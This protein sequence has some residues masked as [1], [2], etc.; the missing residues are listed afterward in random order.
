[1]SLPGHLLRGATAAA[2]LAVATSGCSDAAQMSASRS[3][4]P[5]A[6]SPSPTPDKVAIAKQEILA[7]YRGTFADMDVAVA[8]GN[9]ND[10]A[11]DRHAIA[12]ARTQLVAAVDFYLQQ[13][14]VPKGVPQAKIAFKSLDLYSDPPLATLQT[15]VDSSKVPL[16]DAKTGK[17]ARGFFSRPTLDTALMTVWHGRWV[18]EAFKNGT[19]RC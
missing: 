6:A 3:P 2:I 18:V 9:R 5:T 4:S 1:M 14:V 19:T 11:L 8:H 13:G 15:C 12:G 7:A 10:P 16:V 17:P